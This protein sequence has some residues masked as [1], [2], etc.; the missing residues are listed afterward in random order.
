MYIYIYIYIYV[1]ISDCVKF[2]CELPM[3]PN[4]T[5]LGVKYF[6]TNRKPCKLLT[7]YSLF[8]C[9]SGGD[10]QIRDIGQKF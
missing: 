3:L 6:Y 8:G 2:V 9:L 1:Y 5:I 10:G 7:G 4:N